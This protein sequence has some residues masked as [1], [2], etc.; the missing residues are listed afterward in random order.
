MAKSDYTK[1]V[2]IIYPDKRFVEQDPVRGQGHPMGYH[3]VRRFWTKT[4]R[5]GITEAEFDRRTNL[6]NTILDG[7][8]NSGHRVH[9]ATFSQ[10]GNLKKP[11]VKNIHSTYDVK[12]EDKVIPVG[13]SYMQHTRQMMYPNET[14]VLS[15]INLGE[16]SVF[17]GFHASDCV[18]RFAGSASLLGSRSVVDSMLTEDWFKRVECSFLYDMSQWMIDRGKELQDDDDDDPQEM[19]FLLFNERLSREDLELRVP[20]GK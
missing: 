19:K 9:W 5:M 16:E 18:R 13:I 7:Y 8:R 14:E 10:E 17:G 12:K 2:V 1:S 20:H 6:V 4:V 3:M 11:D 15:R